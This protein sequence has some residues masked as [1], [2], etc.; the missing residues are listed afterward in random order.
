MSPGLN[1]EE[2]Q[3]RPQQQLNVEVWFKRFL[4]DFLMA[5]GIRGGISFIPLLFNLI[6]ARK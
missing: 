5:W 4:R 3:V 6:K 1:M 2:T